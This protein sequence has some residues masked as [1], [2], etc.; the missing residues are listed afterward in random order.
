M[1][2]LTYAAVDDLALMP[3]NAVRSRDP[4][5]SFSMLRC[6]DVQLSR[7][8]LVCRGLTSGSD[9]KRSINTY[10]SP[11]SKSVHFESQEFA[12]V[13]SFQRCLLPCSHGDQCGQYVAAGIYTVR[14]V[15]G[16][17]KDAT[18]DPES[19]AD[20]APYSA[21]NT[22]VYKLAV[23]PPPPRSVWKKLVQQQQVRTHAN[24]VVLLLSCMSA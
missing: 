14:T 3:T 15:V 20:P 16:K 8:D 21:V 9:A 12:L 6:Q 13:F 1:Q 2:L 19:C 4:N 7:G 23:L 22:L 10:R 5:G 24:L 11:G 18:K 17:L